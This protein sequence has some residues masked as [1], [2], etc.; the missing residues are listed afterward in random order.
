MM[1]S[2]AAFEVRDH[3]LSKVCDMCGNVTPA[4]VMSRSRQRPIVQA[5]HLVLWA[6]Y[7]IENLPQATICA[8]MGLDQTSVTYAVNK[9]RDIRHFNAINR[10]V[11]KVIENL[12][13]GSH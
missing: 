6:L 10:E 9:M 4:Q 3:Y 11:A 2:K 5:R 12:V 7:D 13:L 1:P 8:M